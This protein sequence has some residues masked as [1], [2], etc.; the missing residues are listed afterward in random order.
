MTWGGDGLL[1][2]IFES[3]SFK[4]WLVQFDC[5]LSVLSQLL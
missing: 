4:F 1:G 3:H 2:T 5:I